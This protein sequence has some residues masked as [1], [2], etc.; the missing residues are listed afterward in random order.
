MRSGLPSCCFIVLATLLAL[1]SAFA[2]DAPVVPRLTEFLRPLVHFPG[3]PVY[4]YHY[5]RLDRLGQ[6]PGRPIDWNDPR[7][8]DHV[9]EW[10]RYY[11]NE[12]NARYGDRAGLLT[13]S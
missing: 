1:T 10:T 9:G 11:F 6:V 3:R 12:S 4:V 8:A 7:V 5:A 13:S 2:G